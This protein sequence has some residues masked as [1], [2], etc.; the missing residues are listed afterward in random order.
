MRGMVSERYF[1]VTAGAIMTILAV[2]AV[3]TVLVTYRQGRMTEI[4][5]LTA[6][7]LADV[8]SLMNVRFPQKTRPVGFHA[9]V[10]PISRFRLRVEV[11]AAEFE[12]FLASTP[13]PADAFAAAPRTVRNEPNLPSWW[14]PDSV[15]DAKSG[16]A[17]VPGA[18]PPATLR[19]LHSPPGEQPVDVYLEFEQS[20]AR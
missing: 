1:W 3:T 7:Q 11:P 19:L 4:T 9:H 14:S 12:S 5:D 6:E 8:G 16:A 20:S 18:S 17:P 13:I 15:E 2:T 10:G